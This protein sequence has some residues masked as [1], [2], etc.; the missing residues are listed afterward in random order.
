MLAETPHEAEPNPSIDY[1]RTEGIEVI[2]VSG[3]E[4]VRKISNH[5][6]WSSSSVAAAFL[7]LK[8]LDSL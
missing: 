1:K 8:Y 2:I 7:A 5:E 4:L 3:E 6:M